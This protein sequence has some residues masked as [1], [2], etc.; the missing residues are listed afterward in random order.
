MKKFALLI[1]VSFYTLIS[2]ALNPSREYAM[3]PSDFNIEY[4]EIDIP[5]TDDMTLKGWYFKPKVTSNKLI[6]LSDDGDGNMADFMEQIGLFLSL[7]YHV[8]TYD[9]RGYGASSDFRIVNKFFTYAKFVDDLEAVISFSEKNYANIRRISLYGLG[10]GAGLATSIGCIHP[11]ISHIISDSPYTSF[12]DA[13][14]RIKE[15]KGEDVL[16]PIGHDKKKIEPKY[17]L[18]QRASTSKIKILYINGSED[19]LCTSKDIKLLIKI[20][21]ATSTSFTVKGADGT[22]TYSTDK[23][24]YFAQVK[25]FLES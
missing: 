8:I 5:S 11:K 21:P 3:L 6:I 24:T 15:V 18:E 2:F 13:K 17:A 25:E 16:L 14:A 10:I 9:Y 1:I 7:N 22:N 20:R 4:E 19:E 23:E 12:E